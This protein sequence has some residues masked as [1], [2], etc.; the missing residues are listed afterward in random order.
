MSHK[1]A[2]KT[3]KIIV[4]FCGWLLVALGVRVLT[5]QFMRAHLQDP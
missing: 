3:Q 5:L 1:K 2:H 4:L